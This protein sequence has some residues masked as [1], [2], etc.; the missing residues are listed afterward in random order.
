MTYNYRS[1]EVN[2]LEAIER[3]SA[4]L[5]NCENQTLKNAVQEEILCNLHM[6][7]RLREMQYQQLGD[8]AVPKI[9]EHQDIEL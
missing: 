5:S 2:T 4:I 3:L 1:Q 6:L 7:H 8:I 9:Q